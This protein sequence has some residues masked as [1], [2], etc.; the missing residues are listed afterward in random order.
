MQTK[1]EKLG[2]DLVVRIPTTVLEAAG[3]QLDE[4]VEIVTFGDAIVLKCPKTFKQNRLNDLLKKV[5]PE[6]R[7]DPMEFRVNC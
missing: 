1:I 2:N 5:T 3:I 6:T 4:S 7:H